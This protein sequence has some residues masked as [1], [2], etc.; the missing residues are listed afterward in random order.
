[1]YF[2]TLPYITDMSYHLTPMPNH[3][4]ITIWVGT[5]D[6][7][8]LIMKTAAA[9]RYHYNSRKPLESLFMPQGRLQG[10]TIPPEGLTLRE[11]RVELRGSDP[12]VVQLVWISPIH[13]QKHL[14]ALV[15]MTKTEGNYPSDDA[16]LARKRAN[17]AI[18]RAGGKPVL[19]DDPQTADPVCRIRYISDYCIARGTACSTNLVTQVKSYIADGWVPQGGLV[20]DSQGSYYQALVRY[21]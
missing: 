4:Q 12:V 6:Q 2:F 21:T 17:R 20:K 11:C 3:L 19:T 16:L 15:A 10:H 7:R 9:V 5:A 18:E 13:R 14:I 8:D 1:M